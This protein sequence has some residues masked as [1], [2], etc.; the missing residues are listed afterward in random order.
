MQVKQRFIATNNLLKVQFVSGLTP[1]LVQITET[2]VD[3][4]GKGLDVT[5][6]GEMRG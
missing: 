5:Q 6:M 3:M 2:F 1:A 4:K